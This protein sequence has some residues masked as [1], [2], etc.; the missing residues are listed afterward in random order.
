M[1]QCRKKYVFKLQ[2]V[3]LEWTRSFPSSWLCYISS[4]RPF[5]VKMTPGLSFNKYLLSP[6]RPCAVYTSR[7]PQYGPFSCI[8]TASLHSPVLET[9]LG[10]GGNEKLG[11]EWSLSNLY[12][13]F[14]PLCVVSMCP[15]SRSLERCLLSGIQ[16]LTL[17]RDLFCARHWRR[18]QN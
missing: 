3:S 7:Q 18:Y 4:L 13:S 8:V 9:C 11:T 16:T 10:I 6:N 2:Q 15:F 1:C 14:F 5:P 12:V 17:I